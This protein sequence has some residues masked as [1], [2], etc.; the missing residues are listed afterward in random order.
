MRIGHQESLSRWPSAV[1][2]TDMS[3]TGWD[4]HLQDLTTAG[5]WTSE[6]KELHISRLSLNTFLHQIIGEPEVIMSDD[7]AVVA[8]LEKQRH[9]L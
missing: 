3:H 8:Y 7:A 1:I 2:F 5:T 9:S 4:V 6:E